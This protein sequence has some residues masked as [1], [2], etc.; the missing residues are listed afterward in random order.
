LWIQ[1]LFMAR[2]TRYN[3]MWKFVCDLR[4]V[5]GF[6]WALRFP[7]PINL[8]PRYNWNTVES[9]N[10]MLYI[11]IYWN[12]TADNW[13]WLSIILLQKNLICASCVCFCCLFSL[14]CKILFI[15]ICFMRFMWS[16]FT[17][18]TCENT[19]SSNAT[20]RSSVCPPVTSLYFDKQNYLIQF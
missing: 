8:T 4:Q 11:N 5:G 10:N 15:V 13:Y 9:G 7:P 3:I 12:W 2:C 18:L 16:H 6:L 19:L 20:F 17:N 1:T 14:T